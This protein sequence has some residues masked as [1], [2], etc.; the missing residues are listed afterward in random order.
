MA[1]YINLQNYWHPLRE[2]AITAH[3]ISSR[4]ADEPCFSLNDKKVHK[5]VFFLNLFSNHA[6]ELSMPIKKIKNAFFQTSNYSQPYRCQISTKSTCT[7]KRT[8]NHDLKYC[9]QIKLQHPSYCK[10]RLKYQTNAFFSS[11]K[12]ANTSGVDCTSDYR[13]LRLASFLLHHGIH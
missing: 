6:A 5:N 8:N 2:K 9:V 11:W 1:L 12:G 13:C 10:C 7:K 3:N 4:A